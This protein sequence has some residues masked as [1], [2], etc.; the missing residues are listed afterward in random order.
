MQWS[1]DVTE[2]AH[3]TEIKDPSDSTNNPNFE[4]QICHYLDR[5][6]KRRRFD[7][8][9][10]VREARVSLRI[11]RSGKKGFDSDD[12]E[13]LDGSEE[14]KMCKTTSSLLSHIKPINLTTGRRETMQI[15]F[16]W[17][18]IFNVGY[19]RAH[20]SPIELFYLLDRLS[21]F[22]ATQRLNK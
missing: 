2:R 7:L 13:F 21:A 6:D 5:A 15:I 10:A 17:P 12:E 22:Y 14:H 1:A 11:V 20:S 16:N 8:A 4:P 18:S 3:F 19:T 9:T